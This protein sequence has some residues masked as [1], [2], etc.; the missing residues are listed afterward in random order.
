MLFPCGVKN[1]NNKKNNGAKQPRGDSNVWLLLIQKP[2]YDALNEPSRGFYTHSWRFLSRL[3]VLGA[4]WKTR[5][6]ETISCTTIHVCTN[7]GHWDNQ[8]LFILS[9][10]LTRSA[11]ICCIRT[12]LYSLARSI[13]GHGRCVLQSKCAKPIVFS[14]AMFRLCAETVLL[15]EKHVVSWESTLE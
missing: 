3:H 4:C 2:P 7:W 9:F 6:S 1:N 5:R 10:H 14:V 15:L 8:S 12:S 13:H 11:C